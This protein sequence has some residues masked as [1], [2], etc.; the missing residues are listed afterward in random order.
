MRE[1]GF[2]LLLVLVIA[3]LLVATAAILFKSSFKS[4]P[5]GLPLK[6]PEEVGISSLRLQKGNA[7]Q[8]DVS[9]NLYAKNVLDSG[10]T[11]NTADEALK[12][13]EEFVGDT[14]NI[15]IDGYAP[16][17]AQGSCQAILVPSTRINFP[18]EKI[19]KNSEIQVI[20]AL[21]GKSNQFTIKRRENILELSSVKVTNVTVEKEPLI[22]VVVP[23]DLY[24]WYTN[25]LEEDQQKELIE[26]AKSKNIKLAADVY[27]EIAKAQDDF[28]IFFQRKD[29]DRILVVDVPNEAGGQ[30]Q[31][32]GNIKGAGVYSVW[33]ATYTQ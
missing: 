20:V 21:K 10:C 25:H 9:L 6:T 29:K 33:A 3:A 24:I 4:W 31:P 17:F 27:P 7:E 16:N 18:L 8:W 15:K 12:T 13:K 23:N 11:L 22:G 19:S 30:A 32:V 28:E 2:A 14:L 5:F 1:K 26:L